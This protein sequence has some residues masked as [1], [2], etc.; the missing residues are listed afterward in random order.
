MSP[1]Q[2]RVSVLLLLLLFME[3]LRSPTVGGF[4]KSLAVNPFKQAAS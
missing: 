4:F 1:G 3:A 2:W